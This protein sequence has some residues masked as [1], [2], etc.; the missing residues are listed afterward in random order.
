M[1]GNHDGRVI[2]VLLRIG[3]LITRKAV[4]QGD[5]TGGGDRKKVIVV[6]LRINSKRKKKTFEK[7]KILI[8]GN[9]LRIDSNYTGDTFTGVKLEEEK[10]DIVMRTYLLKMVIRFNSFLYYNLDI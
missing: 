4:L 6:T 5:E 3:S 9:L 8:I 10:K 7:S 2:V 1:Q